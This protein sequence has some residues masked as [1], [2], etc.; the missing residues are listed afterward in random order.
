MPT[1]PVRLPHTPP[2]CEYPLPYSPC[3]EARRR[4]T[5]IWKQAA[6]R[7][8]SHK[9]CSL[10]RSV[11]QAEWEAFRYRGFLPTDRTQT[12]GELCLVF[13]LQLYRPENVLHSGVA[14]ATVVNIR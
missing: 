9:T 10:P 7:S 13:S 4:H 1:R 5:L 3:Q 2:R 11:F 8:A 6:P 12:Q 14:Q